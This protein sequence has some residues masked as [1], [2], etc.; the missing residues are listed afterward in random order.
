[1]LE[2]IHSTNPVVFNCDLVTAAGEPKEM[3]IKL[4]GMKLENESVILGIAS[5]IE[6]DL[7]IRLCERESQIYKI[8]NYMTQIDLV[9]KRISNAMTKYG[10]EE[11]IF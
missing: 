11:E 2:L 1:M 9:C 6:D 5:N 7:L 4:Q 3:L 8:E 10:N